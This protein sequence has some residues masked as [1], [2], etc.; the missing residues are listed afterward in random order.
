MYE[1]DRV[2]NIGIVFIEARLGIAGQK[3]RGNLCVS[4]YFNKRYGPRVLIG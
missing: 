4:V 3:F 2:M 1:P